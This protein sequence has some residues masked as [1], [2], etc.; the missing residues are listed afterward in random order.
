SRRNAHIFLESDIRILMK[1]M[2]HY[3]GD[4]CQMNGFYE[5]LDYFLLD[6]D[7]FV[8]AT[9]EWFNKGSTDEESAHI[10]YPRMYFIELILALVRAGI[11][12]NKNI[13]KA[14]EILI[15]EVKTI[16]FKNHNKWKEIYI[17]IIQMI[18]GLGSFSI[19]R[20]GKNKQI[21]ESIV[22]KCFF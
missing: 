16:K 1:R 21:L 20:N 11:K 3:S 18:S 5:F 13:N 17:D 22:H 14:I 8:D 4:L 6:S 12:D 19:E 10:L 7:S 15:S 2:T 9:I